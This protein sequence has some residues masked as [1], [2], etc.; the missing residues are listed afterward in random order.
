MHSINYIFKPAVL[1][2]IAYKYC[3]VNKNAHLSVQI[4]KSTNFSSDKRLKAFLF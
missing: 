3:I 4:Y 1:W 2:S